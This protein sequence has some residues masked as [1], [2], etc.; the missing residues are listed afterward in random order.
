MCV[1]VYMYV[2]ERERVCVCARERVCV[3]ARERECVYVRERA[4]ESVC[5]G[6]GGIERACV[7]E[8]DHTHEPHPLLG[9]F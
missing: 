6:G 1:C 3:C 7:Y 2:Y 8:W 9:C 5:V 4:G